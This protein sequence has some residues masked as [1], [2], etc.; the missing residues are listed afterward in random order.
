MFELEQVNN[1]NF[2]YYSRYEEIFESDEPEV[3]AEK[4]PYEGMMQVKITERKLIKKGHGI[5]FT[6]FEK[7]AMI[8]GAVAVIG[9]LIFATVFL[10][11]KAR[12]KK[13][14]V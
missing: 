14:K 5:I 3:E 11:K 12:K 7:I 4:D 6:L 8:A 2:S 1:E 13:L 9:G 10:I